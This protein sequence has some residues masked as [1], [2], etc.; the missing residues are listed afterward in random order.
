LLIATVL[1]IYKPQ[2]V[3]SYGL[4]KERERRAL[5]QA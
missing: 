1:A 2:G 3:T 4:R 5:R